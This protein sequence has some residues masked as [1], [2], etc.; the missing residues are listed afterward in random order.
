M[1]SNTKTVSELFEYA[2]ALEKAA[3]TLYLELEKMFSHYTE[4]ASFWHRYAN[5]EN[6]HAS[7]LENI[8]TN[9]DANRLS[10]QADEDMLKKV[11]YC[12]EQSSIS[13][14]VNIKTLD[15]A[16]KLAVE[17]E[18]S[19]TNAIFEFM[20]VNFSTDELA[21]SH[22]FLRAQ[23]STHIARLENDFPYK[24]RITRQGILA[25]K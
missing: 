11:L 3:E 20:I 14:L 1:L 23:L 6:G 17:L 7:Y 21:K 22:K 19:E 13:R 25:L 24:S 9:V 18:N 15:D 4:V 10:N 12:L 5:E 16:Y 2:I 8:K